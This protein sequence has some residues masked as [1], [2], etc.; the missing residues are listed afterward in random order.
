[1]FIATPLCRKSKVVEILEVKD[2]ITLTRAWGRGGGEW[3]GKGQCDWSVDTDVQAHKRGK[4]WGSVTQ[5]DKHRTPVCYIFLNS[6][7]GFLSSSH[8]EMIS[9]YIH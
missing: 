2:R 7:N 5:Q 6:Q 9:I 1:M 3:M 8:E 4:F